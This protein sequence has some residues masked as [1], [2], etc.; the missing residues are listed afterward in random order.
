MT[1]E[2]AVTLTDPRERA[3]E[4]LVSHL[5]VAPGGRV[6]A[7]HWHPTVE[8]RFLILAGEV[9]FLIDGRE[10]TL[11]PGESATVHRGVVHDWWQVGEVEAQALVEVR[12]GVAFVEMVGSMFGLA[13][14]GKVSPEGMPDPLQLA[15]M[16]REYRDVISF[17]KPP[18]LVQKLTIPPLAAVGRLLGRKPM[19]PEY[20]ASDEFEDPDPA[21]LAE[22]T[23]DGRLRDFD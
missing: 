4:V 16:G 21:A 20:L 5:F 7:P 3:D 2:R 13:R 14:D 6:A 22:M 10:V 12:P 19:Y 23:E 8:E 18:P 11:R 15:V 9:G 1:G 17:T